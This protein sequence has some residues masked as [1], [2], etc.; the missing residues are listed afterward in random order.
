MATLSY[1]D[2]LAGPLFRTDLNGFDRNRLIFGIGATFYTR[3]EL[4]LRLEY[5]SLFGSD[6]EQSLLFN[7][8]KKY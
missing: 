6:D 4:T 1:A 8:E 2:L 5:R 3:R 7:L